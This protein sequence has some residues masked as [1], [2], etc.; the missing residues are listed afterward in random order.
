MRHSKI[1]SKKQRRSVRHGQRSR[2]ETRV[3]GV[4]GDQLL[5]E[6][7]FTSVQYIFS[8]NYSHNV[9]LHQILISPSANVRSIHPKQNVFTD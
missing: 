6:E 4:K 2:H 1:I 8:W 7:I 5:L 3:S 9:I